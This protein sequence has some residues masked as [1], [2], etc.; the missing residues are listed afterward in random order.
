MSLDITLVASRPTAVFECNITHNLA[1]MAREAG[2]Y[3]P[4]WAPET[5]APPIIWAGDLIPYL[6]KGLA[7]LEADHKRF[8]CLAPANGWGTYEGLVAGA[9]QYLAACRANPDAS[10][11]VSR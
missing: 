7:E 9:R 8:F 1:N 11:E 6:E 10:V 5:I 4:M 3:A 2:L